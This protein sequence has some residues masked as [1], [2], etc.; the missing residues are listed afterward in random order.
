MRSLDR[1]RRARAPSKSPPE[2]AQKRLQRSQ[3]SDAMKSHGQIDTMY[4]CSTA[5]R[6]EC[7]AT[8]RLP[9]AR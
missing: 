9:V 3:Q 7:V 1:G 6:T 8:G 4:P 5:Q 2:R